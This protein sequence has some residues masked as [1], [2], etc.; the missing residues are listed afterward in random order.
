[1]LVKEAILKFSAQ[2]ADRAETAARGI[3]QQT[4]AAARSA[5]NLGR[6][7]RTAATGLNAVSAATG[8][9]FPLLSA[10]ARIGSSAA[11]GAPGGPKAMA[12]AAGV[13]VGAE[14]FGAIQRSR[15]STTINVAPTINVPLQDGDLR[16][17]LRETDDALKRAIERR[18]EDLQEQARRDVGGLNLRR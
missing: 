14:I 13:Q 6:A 12:I 18:L 2:G 3:A 4:E 16:R 15:E 1:M 9:D 17:V 11:L 10:A 5:A 8:G 7:F